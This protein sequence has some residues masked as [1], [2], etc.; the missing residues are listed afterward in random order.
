[1]CTSTTVSQSCVL[2]MFLVKFQHRCV[3]CTRFSQWGYEVWE[4]VPLGGIFKGT[5]DPQK[6]FFGLPSL[7]K[8][9]SRISY[10]INSNTIGTNATRGPSKA[11][12]YGTI[13]PSSRFH[14]KHFAGHVKIAFPP[15]R[16]PVEFC[17][18]TKTT[19]VS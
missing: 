14:S 1:M 12:L 5:G 3:K 16:T 9:P 8:V 13:S 2:L 17:D 4:V 10:P 6:H 15:S 11:L 7:S 19:S 18:T